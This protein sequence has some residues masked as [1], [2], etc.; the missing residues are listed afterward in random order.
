MGHYGV[1]QEKF[2]DRIT[3]REDNILKRDLIKEVVKMYNDEIRKALMDGEKVNIGGVGSIIPKIHVPRCY[4]LPTN[5][6]NEITPYIGAYFHK[7]RKFKDEINGKLKKNIADTGKVEL[8][9]GMPP[10]PQNSGLEN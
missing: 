1:T 5:A 10:L 9:N 6:N 7:N 4:C 3:N 2:V 8:N